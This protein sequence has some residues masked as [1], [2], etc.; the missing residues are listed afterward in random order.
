MPSYKSKSQKRSSQSRSKNGGRRR[1]NTMRKLRRGRKSRKVMRG[2]GNIVTYD[3]LQQKL[4]EKG[5][6]KSFLL[7]MGKTDNDFDKFKNETMMNTQ[8]ADTIDLSR[9]K[10]AISTKPIYSN[11]VTVI[12]DLIKEE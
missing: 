12:D 10:N 2:G 7:A 11:A 8:N 5:A 4:D 1:K 3:R 6:T 9:I